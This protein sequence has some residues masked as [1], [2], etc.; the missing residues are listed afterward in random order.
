MGTGG[1]SLDTVVSSTAAGSDAGAIFTQLA[2]SEPAFE[3]LSFDGLMP[4][5]A[6]LKNAAA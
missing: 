6:S 2:A 1:E 5:G 4:Y 3:G